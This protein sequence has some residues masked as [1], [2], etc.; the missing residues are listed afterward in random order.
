L[1]F[2]KA[3]IDI[4]LNEAAQLELHA[5]YQ[6]RELGKKTSECGIY[7]DA[8]EYAGTALQIDNPEIAQ[9]I[10]RLLDSLGDRF[11]SQYQIP[12]FES[13]RRSREKS[14]ADI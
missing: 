10:R 14:Q 6:A 13:K 7:R 9:M 3:Q 8:L 12:Y 11:S 1:S 5:G 4:A 2:V